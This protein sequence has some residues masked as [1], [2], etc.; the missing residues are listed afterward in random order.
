MDFIAL[1]ETPTSPL[2][3]TPAALKKLQEQSLEI[4][5]KLYTAYLSRTRALNDAL[6]KIESFEEDT[7]EK[8]LR[9]E[10]LKFQVENLANE[11][12][13]LTKAIEDAETDAEKAR[14]E[15]KAALAE[16]N[17]LAWTAK[18]ARKAS[19]YRSHE[20]NRDSVDDRRGLASP[21]RFPV[22]A[23]PPKPRYS[24]HQ[25]KSS[26]SDSGFESGSDSG[27][28]F[29]PDYAPFTSNSSFSSKRESYVI[30]FSSFSS[31]TKGDNNTFDPSSYSHYTPPASPLKPKTNRG[32]SVATVILSGTKESR[33]SF[34]CGCADKPGWDVVKDLRQENG[35]L[36][37]RVFELEDCLGACLDVVSSDKF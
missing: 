8:D 11:Q 24:L 10:S 29:S 20:E 14:E 12:E 27:S 37:N 21:Q 13:T 30:P 6:N 15:T 2:N 36:K 23:S 16:R 18:P 31:F 25:S 3:C 32:D 1:L 4:I 28:L 19:Q 7:S 33:G 35:Q 9:I 34:T 5:D 22:K 17:R 26:L